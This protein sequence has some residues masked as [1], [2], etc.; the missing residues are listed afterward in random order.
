M[1]YIRLMIAFIK[2]G[3]FSFGGGYAMLPVIEEEVVHINQWLTESEFIDIIAISQMSPG[4]IAINS[5]TFVGY[6]HL[7]LPGAVLATLSV[8]AVPFLLVL[9]ISQFLNKYRDSNFIKGVFSGIRPAV[10]G[11]IAAACISL[12]DTSI[13]DIYSGVIF[14][15]ILLTLIKFKLHPIGAIFISGFL[16]MV[17]YAI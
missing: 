16:G 8:I 5:A 13:T 15:V 1:S 6:T 9:F 14:L 3:A 10:I 7:G 12:V 11:L 4:P 2:I 17:L